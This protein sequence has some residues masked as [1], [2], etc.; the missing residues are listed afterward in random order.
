MYDGGGQGSEFE[1]GRGAEPLG[2]NERILALS[3][4]FF[5]A[6]GAAAP[7][8]SHTR[9]SDCVSAGAWSPGP[10]GMGPLKLVGVCARGVRH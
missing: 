10:T 9:A 7:H 3:R 6:V 1:G 2:E 5:T 8:R 4:A